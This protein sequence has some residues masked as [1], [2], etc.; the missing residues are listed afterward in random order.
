M[1]RYSE[2][3]W[4]GTGTITKTEEKP[5]GTLLLEG[6]ASGPG[7]DRDG[8]IIEPEALRAAWPV[9]MEEGPSLRE[10]HGPVAAGRVLSASVDDEGF[11]RVTALVVDPGTVRK[12]TL[13][14]LRMLSVGGKVL[15]RSPEDPSRITSLRLVELS[16]VDSGAHPRAHIEAVKAEVAAQRAAVAAVEL[17]QK[18]RDVL[19]PEKR[20]AGRAR[21]RQ[22]QILALGEGMSRGAAA[23]GGDEG[24]PEPEPGKCTACGEGLTCPKCSATAPD[25]EEVERVAKMADTIGKLQGERD[26]AIRKARAMAAERDAVVKKLAQ[27]GR[28]RDGARKALAETRSD[29]DAA[30]AEI[31]RRTKGSLRDLSG[32]VV[33]EKGRDLGSTPAP[34]DPQDVASLIKASH[35]NPRPLAG[36]GGPF[37]KGG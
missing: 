34:E 12:V 26:A 9:F 14:V 24:S 33:V 21:R 29:L 15:K 1:K 6:I 22:R 18:E 11:S 3:V 17:V 4:V 5:D 23:D 25:P 36:D 16:L 8:E 10:M 30:H 7:R 32:L 37:R 31:R 2:P 13:G 19:D 20:P 35:R 27:V 28:E